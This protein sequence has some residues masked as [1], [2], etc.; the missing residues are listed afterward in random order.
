MKLIISLCNQP[1]AGH[2]VEYDG[3]TGGT[4]LI[5]I[6]H[7]MIPETMGTT[8][9]APYRDG[10]L[11]L[12]Q[13][14]PTLLVH[15]SMHYEVID[16]WPLPS[17]S[18]PHS[19]AV[20]EGVP[21]VV[22]TGT[23]SVIRVEEGRET[24]Y[25]T[26]ES[27]DQDHIHIN[28]IASHDGRLYASAF[29]P[30]AGVLWSDAREGYVVDLESR[31]P[32]LRP[33]YHPHSLIPTGDGFLIC[34]SSRQRLVCEDGQVLPIEGGYARGLAVTRDEIV[35]GIS[36]GRVRSRSTGIIVNNPADPGLLTDWCGIR[37]YRRNAKG[38]AGCELLDA[39]SLQEYANEV[40]DI[41]VLPMSPAR[42]R[43]FGDDRSWRRL[44]DW[45]TLADRESGAL[46]VPAAAVG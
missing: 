36:R 44:A 34:E 12:V 39:I 45:A 42:R 21:Y 13:T 17:V 25:W 35:V 46:E 20:H 5:R 10:F 41:L 31:K 26:P 27:G 28:S 40:Y 15:L 9:L 38:L 24:V 43:A 4:A 32:L 22:S 16:L 14:E 2:L 3:D 8:G 18:E 11:V 29:G 1:I 19:I 7:P 37:R 23:N 33:L 30:K 6:V